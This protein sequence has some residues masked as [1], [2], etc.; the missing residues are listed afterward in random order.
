MSVK[1]RLR[2]T[3]ALVGAAALLGAADRASAET[4]SLS[5]YNT[6][7]QERATIVFKRNGSFVPNGVQELNQM[8]RDWRRNEAT[9]M[10]PNLFDLVWEVYRDS[11]SSQPIHIISG[12]RS[13]ATNN[14]LRDRSR[15]V[16]KFSQHMLGRAM[17]FYLPDV[18]LDRLRA[19]G[20]KKQVG[21]VGFYPTSGSPFVHMDTGSVRA[22]PRMSRDQLVRL[23]P[24][25]KTLHLPADGAPLPRYEE[26]VAEYRARGGRP[27]GGT[28]VAGT[29]GSGRGLLASIFGIGGGSGDDEEDGSATPKRQPELRQ[30]PPPPGSTR[31]AAAD[32]ESP[33]A[34][35]AS[36]ASSERTELPPPPPTAP[37]AT[38]AAAATPPQPSAAPVPTAQAPGTLVALPIPTPAPRAPGS[39]VAGQ[40]QGQGQETG[41]P[42]GWVQGPQPVAAAQ[43]AE[44][45]QSATAG[46]QPFNGPLPPSK[47][48]S[49][50]VVAAAAPEALPP[51][52]RSKPG[53]GSAA[54]SQPAAEA[55]AILTGGERQPATAADALGF[56]TTAS[57]DPRAGAN[58][59]VRTPGN[60]VVAA[61]SPA[62][63]GSVSDAQPR[64]AAPAPSARPAAKSDRGDP[65]ARL[66]SRPVNPRETRLMDAASTRTAAFGE[67]RHPDQ[68]HLPQLIVK[69]K[70]LVLSGFGA[71]VGALRSDR[72]AG[73]AVTTLV[74]IR[75][76]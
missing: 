3:T 48:G 66:V 58:P 39:L 7:T 27:A 29:G 49:P 13:P 53:P 70:Q 55:I 8:L 21:G 37:R 6:H 52:P 32:D 69:P 35:P 41:I 43:P 75:T 1:S 23:F 22:W 62:T 4:R 30:G 38:V 60:G 73:P 24:N 20:M 72:F 28:D 56:A 12:Y 46:L 17:D 74:V 54:L 76:E 63:G 67:F 36:T 65:L 40:G 44:T 45:A 5:L 61:L 47:P 59:I 2:W 16:A 11:G 10:D 57:V 68:E 25:G 19:I 14:A 34:E 9:K 26:A 15:G 42:P 33:P 64:I 71:G 51:A 18:P 31:V 50:T